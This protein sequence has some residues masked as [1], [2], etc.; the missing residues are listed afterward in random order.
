MRTLNINNNLKEVVTEFRDAKFVQ[1]NP[2]SIGRP[3]KYVPMPRFN[4]FQFPG[5]YSASERAIG[6]FRGNGHYLIGCM[7]ENLMIEGGRDGNLAWHASHTIFQPLRWTVSAIAY[8]DLNPPPSFTFSI[9][10][11]SKRSWLEIY[12]RPLASDQRSFCSFISHIAYLNGLVGCIKLPVRDK[13]EETSSNGE[14]EIENNVPECQSSINRRLGLVLIIFAYLC[15][16]PG[17]HFFYG[18]NWKGGA[19]VL[20]IAMIAVHAG[21]SILLF[22]CWRPLHSLL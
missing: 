18:G 11:S 6:H 8:R 7:R 9:K 10:A 14:N 17:A 1:L 4:G 16:F 15:A 22:G 5:G 2:V 21:L 12:D 13:S 19:G 20:V 3:S